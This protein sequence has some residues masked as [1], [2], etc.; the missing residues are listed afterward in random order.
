MAPPPSRLAPFTSAPG[1]LLLLLCGSF[2]V[3]RD[4]CVGQHR[5]VCVLEQAALALTLALSNTANCAFQ[6]AIKVN[7]FFLRRLQHQLRS[8]V[9]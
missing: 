1:P 3:A 6:S 8:I 4:V 9:N 2:S 5:A 7:E